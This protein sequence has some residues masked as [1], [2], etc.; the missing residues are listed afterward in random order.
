[1]EIFGL[2][3]FLRSFLGETPLSSEKKEE[4]STPK[5]EG[6]ERQTPPCEKEDKNVDNA[7]PSPS[8]QDAI[9]RFLSDHETRVSRSK[10]P[11]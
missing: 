6:E 7:T 2:F 9:L 8:S 4:F 3:D 11:R 1:M 5:T 10:K